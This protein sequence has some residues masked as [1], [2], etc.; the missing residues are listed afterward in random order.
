MLMYPDACPPLRQHRRGRPFIWINQS[1]SDGKTM[2]AP[3]GRNM[4]ANTNRIRF[5]AG[6]TFSEYYCCRVFAV[7]MFACVIEVF[8]CSFCARTRRYPAEIWSG[9]KVLVIFLCVCDSLISLETLDRSSYYS[10][11]MIFCMLYGKFLVYDPTFVFFK[12]N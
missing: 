1:L 6:K 8:A 7:C 12:K 4:A 11:C 2:A 9:W 3:S 10:L 5:C